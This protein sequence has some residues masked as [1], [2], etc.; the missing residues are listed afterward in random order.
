[1]HPL[2]PLHIAAG[3]LALVA[4][5]AA[6]AIR[7]GSPIHARAGTIF[8]AS[9]LVMTLSGAVIA[10]VRAEPGTGVI[11]LFTAYLVATG[12]AAAHRRDGQARGLERAGLAAALACVALFATLAILSTLSPTG[13]IDSLPAP[14]H[15][16]YGALAALAAWYDLAFIRRGRLTG[17]QRLARHVWRISTALLIAALSFFLGQ[18]DEFPKWMQGSPV[19]FLPPLSVLAV[20]LFW[21][22]RLRFGKRF[23][24]KSRVAA[25]LST[26]A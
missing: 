23:G 20:M 24:R 21:L 8:F 9:M 15:Y 13:K 1:M 18:Q 19:F 17:A 12:W 26:A 3:T 6:L 16:I 7:K 5:F 22:V 2:M 25:A 4:G 11:G 10:A 14:I